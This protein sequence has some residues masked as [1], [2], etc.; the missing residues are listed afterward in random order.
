M[1]RYLRREGNKALF[2][3]SLWEK[4]VTRIM[5]ERQLGRRALK[6]GTEATLDQHTAA[7]QK[8]EGE[9]NHALYQDQK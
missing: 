7:D 2:R 5:G 6:S 1:S 8:V 9:S 4:G 3:V